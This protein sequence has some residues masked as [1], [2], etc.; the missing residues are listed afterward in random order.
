MSAAEEG[1]IER[2]LFKGNHMELWVRI[3]EIL[4]YS[5]AS[6]DD[7]EFKVGESVDVLIY[8]LYVFDQNKTYVIENSKMNTDNL[9][10][11]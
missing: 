1:I 10:Y 7:E 2:I 6:I 9:Y 8:R 5:N 11:I 3:D 4:I